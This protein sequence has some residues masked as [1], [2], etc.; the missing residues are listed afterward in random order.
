MGC[1]Y[2]I[3]NLSTGDKYIG[4]TKYSAEHR[5]KQHIAEA[6]NTDRNLRLYNAIR[7]YGVEH[8][9]LTVLED[10]IDELDLNDKEIYYISLFDTFKNGYNNTLG[11]GGMNGY[12]HSVETRKKMGIAISKSMWK[13][14][15]PERTAKIIAAQKGRPFTLEH[16]Q[17]ISE[18]CVGKRKG[19]ENPFYGRKH[20]LETRQHMSEVK[21]KYYVQ[22]VDLLTNEILNTFNSVEDAAKYCQ[23]NNFTT[24]KLSSV[25]Y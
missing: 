11:G 4:Q 6:L 15:T 25:M 8:F 16:R 24:A 2:L 22:Q 14:N 5:Y 10:N 18:S 13:I 1:I 19:K 21:I 7:K 23:I 20:T 12:H 3:T 17:H 9:K